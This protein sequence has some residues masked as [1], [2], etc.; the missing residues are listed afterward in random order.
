[1]LI[2]T[3]MKSLTPLWR[4]LALIALLLPFAPL[5]AVAI[6]MCLGSAM[7]LPF[8]LLGLLLYV[9]NV[10]MRRVS[11]ALTL[12]IAVFSNVS[13]SLLVIGLFILIKEAKL[14]LVANLTLAACEPK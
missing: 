6:P 4:N 7:K 3:L 10:M 14:A 13:R 1:M 11:T 2:S 12:I 9:R 8:D 5:L